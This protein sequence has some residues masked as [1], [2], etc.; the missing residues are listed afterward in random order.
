[1]H[2]LDSCPELGSVTKSEYFFVAETY[3]DILK[4]ADGFSKHFQDRYKVGKPSRED[5]IVFAEV[6]QMAAPRSFIHLYTLHYATTHSLAGDLWLEMRAGGHQTPIEVLIGSGVP[7]DGQSDS[8]FLLHEASFAFKI[9]SK[10][11]SKAQTGYLPPSVLLFTLSRRLAFR[12]LHPPRWL[13]LLRKG[14]AVSGLTFP[15]LCP[16][17]KQL[18]RESWAWSTPAASERERE[19]GGKYFLPLF[20]V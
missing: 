16:T 3:R 1:M 4:N 20:N 5:I 2:S 14:N 11:P 13:G 18:C 12:L 19:R 10:T 7:G 6:I 8:I 9:L 17:Q 15:A